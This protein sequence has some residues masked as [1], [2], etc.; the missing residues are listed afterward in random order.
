MI[1]EVEE[2]EMRD[3]ADALR[4]A[5]PTTATIRRG[6]NEKQKRGKRKEKKKRDSQRSPYPAT[7]CS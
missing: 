7:W 1:T 2:D 6:K 4:P 3:V 5:P